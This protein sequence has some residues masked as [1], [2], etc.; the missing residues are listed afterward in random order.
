MPKTNR[1]F[2]PENRLFHFPFFYATLSSITVFY[3]VPLSVLR[4][5]PANTTLEPAEIGG[6]GQGLISIEFQ[7]Y[8]DHL[9][10]GQAPSNPGMSVTNEVELDIISYPA[11]WKKEGRVPDI[12]LEDFVLGQEQTKTI[13]SY[14]LDV[15]ADNLVAVK[16]GA[17]EFGEQK[18]FTLFDYQVPCE[19][20]AAASLTDWSYT[21]L[22]PALCG[23]VAEEPSEE[24]VS[25]ASFGI[26]LQ[27]RSTLRKSFSTNGQSFADYTAQ[28]DSGEAAGLRGRQP[29]P[30]VRAAMCGPA[31]AGAADRY[32]AGL[33]LEYPWGFSDIS[34]RIQ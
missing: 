18:F 34:N 10:V 25:A 17:D 30:R 14:R 5:H 11:R 33:E 3:R 31:T 6:R 29:Q 22:D 26:H 27:D 1:W 2:P 9:G 20:N 28:H 7:N 12:S 24:S 19:N 13:G 32:S 16:A 15:P 4:P 8:T 23:A 21:V